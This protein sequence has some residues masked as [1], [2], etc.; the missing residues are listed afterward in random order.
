MGNRREFITKVS[1]GFCCLALNNIS[2]L[3]RNQKSEKRVVRFGIVSDVHQDLQHDAVGRLRSFIDAA[4]QWNP[5]F[6]IQLGDLSHGKGLDV[7][8][9]V[10][11]QFPG[12][13]YSVMGN[14]D[15]DHS[16]K[17]IVTRQ[18]NMPARYYSFDSGDVHFVTLD[19]N[20]MRKD[21][22]YVDFE[23]G[24]YYKAEMEDRDLISPEELE[25][26]KKDLFEADK[27][28]V[29]FSHQGLD[30][31]WLGKGC[32]NRIE[33][34]NVINEVNKRENGKVIAC[35]CGHHHVDAYQKI[36][37]VHYFQI[38]SAS[39]FWSDKV[40][41]YSNGHMVE[42]KD[43]LFAFVTLDLD[44]GQIKMEGVKSEFLPPAPVSTD[45]DGADKVYPYISDRI[46][47]IKLS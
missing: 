1:V 12:K 24:N 31:V 20:Y 18:L 38:N 33:V 39:Y 10:W 41:H 6:I 25:W 9:D 37:G 27:P 42:Y 14:H 30:E 28:V 16:T 8:N 29:I 34:R 23:K 5:D 36:D 2:C 21:G 26:L 43:A 7:I 19:L 4:R 15:T 13:R 17:D 35:F 11:K 45:F 46:I 22:V 47:D 44:S 40:G 3:G 32:P